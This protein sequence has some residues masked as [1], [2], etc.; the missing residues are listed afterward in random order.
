M[1]FELLDCPLPQRN[2]GYECLAVR[3]REKLLI[4]EKYVM[5]NLVQQPFSK[6]T[7]SPIFFSIIEATTFIP[8]IFLLK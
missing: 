4:L 8:K 5:A 7:Y 1:L 2:L 3:C 6:S